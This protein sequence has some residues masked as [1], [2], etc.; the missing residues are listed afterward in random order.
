M[1]KKWIVLF[2][3]VAMMATAFA[4]CT[5]KNKDEEQAK[6]AEQ[7]A[8]QVQQQEKAEQSA[9]VFE[10]MKLTDLEGNEVDSSVFEEHDLT[11]INIWATFCNPCLSEMPHLGE[12]SEEYTQQGG[13]VQIIGIAAD[14]TDL[15]GEVISE[16]V[17][18]AKQIVELT[19]ATYMHLLPN[20]DFMDY[21]MNHVSG[22]P[23][24]F[25]VD[26]QGKIVGDE[27]VGARDKEAWQKEINDRM[28]MLEQ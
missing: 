25:F 12:L 10:T 2:L 9:G 14:L 28:A 13:K 20:A 23:T 3:T 15:N 22:F 26:S 18:A 4:G 6:N 16:N 5:S 11:M 27:V 24:T 21:L 19:G 17:D 7:G 1:V 8:P